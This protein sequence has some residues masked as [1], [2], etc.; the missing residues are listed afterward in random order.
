MGVQY[1]WIRDVD[2]HTYMRVLR[3][4]RA[5]RESVS[6]TARHLLNRYLGMDD[7]A[8]PKAHRVK[9]KIKV[10]RPGCSGTS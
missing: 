9:A 10:K 7:P 2:P 5:R 3:L 1:L 6:E 4:A 8:S